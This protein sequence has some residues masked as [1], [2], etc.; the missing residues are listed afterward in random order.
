MAENKRVLLLD[1]DGTIIVTKS[2]ETFAKDYDDWKFKP[3]FLKAL[4]NFVLDQGIE[5]IH[6]VTNQGGPLNGYGRPGDIIHKVDSVRCE[7]RNMFQF[8]PTHTNGVDIDF[9]IAFGPMKRKPNSLMFDLL[10]EELGFDHK[11]YLMVGDATGLE[12]MIELDKLPEN[13]ADGTVYDYG[14]RRIIHRSSQVKIEHEPKANE[15]Q[16]SFK[17]KDDIYIMRYEA[18]RIHG[19]RP[20]M[21]SFHQ[22]KKDFSDSDK[23][24]A[25]NC[26]IEYMDIDDFIKLSE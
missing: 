20:N 4:V 5:R 24:F 15:V 25:E 1:M 6:I 12:R 7:L 11:N 3:G 2:G 19:G 18:P 26:G 9:D 8:I 21:K 17:Y 16:T 13:I 10:Y 23:M 14:M 22:L